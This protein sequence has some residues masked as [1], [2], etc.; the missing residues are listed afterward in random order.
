LRYEIVIAGIGGQGIV[1]SGTIVG[2]AAAV[3]GG[4][5]ATQIASYGPEAMGGRVYTEVVISDEEID[6]PRVSSPDILVVMSQRGYNEFSR[7]VKPGGLIIYDPDLVEIS[8]LEEVEQIAIPA[9]KEAERLG[10]RI[11]ANMVMIGALT[12]FCDLLEPEMVEEAIRSR[13]RRSL[14]TNLKAFRRGY[15]LA[16]SLR[17]ASGR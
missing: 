10:L 16:L 5:N 17:G 14:E 9:T 13:V 11:S 15:E 8:R 3:F 12:A 6:Y 2:T 4:L 1:L 7:K